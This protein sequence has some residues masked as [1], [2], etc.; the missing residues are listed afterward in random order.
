MR[1]D[2]VENNTY[3]TDQL[4]ETCRLTGARWAVWLQYL[5]PAVAQGIDGAWVLGGAYGLS[6][7]R[8]A[9][10][11]MFLEH[12]R[13]ITWLSG[14]QATGRMRSRQSGSWA[15]KLN[16]K[17]VYLFPNKDAQQV[18]M[19]G[20]EDLDNLA[21][22]F[23]RVL[24][25]GVVSPQRVL[26]LNDDTLE[27]FLLD[28]GGVSYDLPSAL[29]RIL[30]L[31]VRYVPSNGAI[32]SLRYGD[33][34]RNEV[35]WNL[36][37]NIS[38]RQ[39]SLDTSEVL[40]QIVDTR[41]YLVVQDIQDGSPCPFTNGSGS[42]FLSW[43]GIPLLVGKRVIGVVCFLANQRNAFGASVVWR[44][45]LLTSRVAPSIDTMV[46]FAEVS[47]HLEKFAL[48]NE[49]AS[50]T[51][52]GLDIDEVAQRIVRRL[53]RVFK[54]DLVAVFLPSSEGNSLREYG[55]Q[56]Y[57]TLPEG[58]SLARSLAGRVMD[59][60][61]PKRMV[62]I[63][64]SSRYRSL[65][66]EAHSVMAVPLKYRGRVIGVLSLESTDVN[67]FSLRDEQLLVVIASHLAGLLENV[68]LYEE[69]RRRAR[70]LGLIHQVV[71]KV[72]GLA[73]I[74]EIAQEAAVLITER[75]SYESVVVL[76]LDE[77]GEYLVVE[78]VGGVSR[79]TVERGFHHPADQGITGQV[80]ATGNSQLVNN[81][82]N[83]PYY[84]DYPGWVAGSEMC[85]PLR[86]GEMVFGVINVERSL[87]EGFSENDLLTLEA[88]AGVLSTVMMNAASYQKLQTN[89]R[90]LQAV[91]ETALDIGADLDLETLLQRVT[92]RARELVGAKGAELGLVDEEE[93]VVKIKVSDNPWEGYFTGLTIPFL[94]GVAGHVAV[95]GDSMIVDDYNTWP[96]RLLPDEDAPFKT[97][98][99]VPLK[100][101]GK[102]IGT[103]T[104]SDDDPEGGFNLDD[105]QLLELL[106]PQIAVSV[107]NARLYLQLQELIEAERLA[108][109]H[110]VQSA[111]LAAVGELAAGVAH[112][113][114]NPLTT[115]TGFVELVL[116]EV[117]EDGPQRED[118]ELVLREARRAR[119][120]VRRLL[121]F[122]RPGEGFR[123][124]TDLNDLITDVI[125][126][127]RHLAHTGGV[128]IHND[129]GSDLPEVR[130]DR[131]QIKQVL[132]N[133]VHNALQS[134]PQGGRL[135][136]VTR[137][138]SREENEYVT[139]MVKDTGQGI[140][141][142]LIGRIFEPFF[143]TRQPG[144][145]T[146]LGL[147]VSYGIVNDHGGFIDV[148]SKIGE[149]SC[150]TVWLPHYGNRNII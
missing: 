92:R 100:Y 4:K 86:D 106:A 44:A 87:I 102:V 21:K 124:P 77:E 10:L 135:Q 59:T 120:V 94:S 41:Q 98:A 13:T 74:G 115:V 75:F 7:A 14:A 1:K 142:D 95:R 67:A 101:K 20:A 2:I 25:R 18:L 29:N 149:G 126:L 83:N 6:K 26:L 88:L 57:I 109:D 51:A 130:V 24:S 99:G 97:V 150:F 127:V 136:L 60:G 36:P 30:N 103:L 39:V 122:S 123:V 61:L 113:L 38:G 32:I 16:C 35:T 62:D 15:E 69:A 76:L 139:I 134:M 58:R 31:L 3:Q 105:L 112:E 27:N 46:A 144:K 80:L 63:Q 117:P 54:T 56:V 85:V 22:G 91:R 37:T 72:V 96:D 148:E 141:S 131:N 146:G 93:K 55:D 121:D 42:E 132:L 65:S 19:V 73:D 110:L 66:P 133:L 70:N 45:S 34:F 68:R 84:V 52:A 90:H 104:V 5:D 143:T 33:L 28:F 81:V 140:P 50:A 118:L 128:E 137:K 147:S 82:Q 8:H 9:S 53:R 79:E 71:E 43:L 48:L 23:F 64:K 49:L 129:F 107:R 47:H 116:D 12:P 89:F 119:E 114:N 145:G 111:R 40:T 108:K 138:D 17:R 125:A 78:G 11:G